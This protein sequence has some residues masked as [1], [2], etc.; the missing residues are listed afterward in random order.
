M[1]GILVTNQLPSLMLYIDFL[2][3]V[4]PF[5]TTFPLLTA[6]K[7]FVW[8]FCSFGQ[9]K[10]ILQVENAIFYLKDENE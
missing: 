2:V 9:I 7:L 4:I 1:V 10:F 5:T 6:S 8:T 3:F